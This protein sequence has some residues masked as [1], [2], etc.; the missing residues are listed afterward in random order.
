MTASAWNEILA[1]HLHERQLVQLVLSRPV[2]LSAVPKVTVRPV[3]LGGERR[4]Q[5]AFRR[6]PQEFHEN[7][8]T[9]ELLER[10]AAQFGLKFADLHWFAADGD[11][12]ARQKPGGRVQLRR[13]PP[14]KAA[15]PVVA[16]NQPR[17][18]IVPE[19][20]PC[21]FLI[22]IG[23]M[24]ADG[25]VK[26]TMSHKFRQINRY[27]EFV[28][29]ILPEL[30]S[31]GTIHVV[32]FGCG[33]SY[34]TFALHHLL[35]VVHARDVRI[36]GLDLK[37]DVV[38]HCQQ[39]ADRLGCRGLSFRE[40]DIATCVPT[41]PVHLAVSLH[42]CDTATDDALAAAIGWS[43]DVI[44]AV[45]CCQ[46]ELMHTLPS[47]TLPGLTGYGLL[48]ERF[49]ALATDALRARYLECSGYRTQVVEFIDLEHTPKNVLLRA[50]KRPASSAEDDQRRREEYETLKHDLGV[51][52][53]HLDK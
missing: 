1:R 32:D 14:T 16:H 34:L 29:D 26:P 43:C 19:G 45:P 49:A 31:A 6:G 4:Y 41:G 52:A 3:D 51:T 7:L 9:D 23:V 48:K 30:P 42:A 36:V 12:T 46:H 38:A 17:Q 13:K 33:K 39:I 40:G 44:L 15:L 27:L 10:I 20:V 50:V 35:T 5:W 24:S 25:R 47:T 8:S 11:Y 28:E 2:Q 53:W 37:G 22:E 18:H 21:P